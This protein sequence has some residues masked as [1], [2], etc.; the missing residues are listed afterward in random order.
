MSRDLE[1]YPLEDILEEL[2]QRNLSF[3]F[4]WVDHQQFT[5]DSSTSQEIVWGIERGG[6][7]ILQ[8]VL[9]R[10]ING[11]HRQVVKDRTAPGRAE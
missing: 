7:L 11:W 1:L 2:K 6:N 10:F 3:V 8:D 9:V 4:A 5:K